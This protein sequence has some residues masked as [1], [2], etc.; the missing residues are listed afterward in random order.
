MSSGFVSVR[1]HRVRDDAR[2][3]GRDDHVM[4]QAQAQR[5][6]GNEVEGECE[7]MDQRGEGGSGGMPL[8]EHG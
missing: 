8:V 4:L 1:I 2:D 5:R 3:G 7:G 6:R